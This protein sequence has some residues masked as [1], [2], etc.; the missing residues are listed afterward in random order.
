MS[1]IPIAD[2]PE[3]DADEPDLC[4]MS[5]LD[6]AVLKDMRQ[7]GAE[8]CRHFEALLHNTPGLKP[9]YLPERDSV[10]LLNGVSLVIFSPDTFMVLNV[11]F[12]YLVLILLTF[13]SFR[14]CT[15]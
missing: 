10:Y 9:G 2:R 11:V 7:T 13:Y 14:P 15:C 8:Y 1:F 3:D 4:L 5:T 12:H 6:F